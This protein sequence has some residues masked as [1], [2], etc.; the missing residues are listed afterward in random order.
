M[1]NIEDNIK[2]MVEVNEESSEV[3]INY[4]AIASVIDY[5]NEDRAMAQES[6]NYFRNRIEMENDGKAATRE[7]VTKSLEI[8]N[9]ATNQLLKLLEIQAKMLV[10]S[11]KPAG[12]NINVYEGQV[13]INKRELIEKIDKGLI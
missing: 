10:D 7:A 2:D 4:D 1:G 9:N 11:R 5:I 8:K 3:K 13:T 6:F 12:I